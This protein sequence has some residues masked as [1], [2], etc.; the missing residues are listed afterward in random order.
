[1]GIGGFP[2]GHNPKLQNTDIYFDNIVSVLLND[3]T[4]LPF[5]TDTSGLQPPLVSHSIRHPSFKTCWCFSLKPCLADWLPPFP[6]FFSGLKP[7]FVCQSTFQHQLWLLHQSHSRCI[8]FV[9]WHH[10]H[11]VAGLFALGHIWALV[12]QLPPITH[13]RRMEE[14]TC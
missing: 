3:V 10:P 8:L 11:S 12:K 5:A 4:V 2:R 14:F 6:W 1:M 7:K 9:T 13:C